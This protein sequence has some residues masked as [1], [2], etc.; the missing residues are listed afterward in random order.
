M[1]GAHVLLANH[2]S[3]CAMIGCEHLCLSVQSIRGI[4][5]AQAIVEKASIDEVY[6][7]VTAIVDADL[8][9]PQD[10]GSRGAPQ[11]AHSSQDDGEA[12]AEEE[13]HAAMRSAPVGYRR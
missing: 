8:R 5:S 7:D 1:L 9:R 4:R 13:A 3:R 11:P 10:G 2:C 6:V 12:E